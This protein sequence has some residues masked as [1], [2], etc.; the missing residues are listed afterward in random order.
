MT[1]FEHIVTLTRQLTLA[2]KARLLERLSAE[3]TLALETEAYKQIP[4]AQFITLTYGSLADD[5]LERPPQPTL[6]IRDEI[7]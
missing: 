5:P 6:D 1:Y 2:E 7:E 3:L 4:W